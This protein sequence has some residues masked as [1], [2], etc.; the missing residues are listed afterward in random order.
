MDDV[1]TSKCY[2]ARRVG[3]AMTVPKNHWGIATL[4]RQTTQIIAAVVRELGMPLKREA[5]RRGR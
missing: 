1:P 5:S 3:G 4:N 2:G